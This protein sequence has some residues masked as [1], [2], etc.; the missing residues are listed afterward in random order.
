MRNAWLAV[1]VLLIASHAT[2]KDIDV[3]HGWVLY[4]D[5]ST[6]TLPLQRSP[7][8]LSGWKDVVCSDNDISA[9]VGQIKVFREPA[10]NADNFIAKLAAECAKIS[11]DTNADT[12]NEAYPA[13]RFEVAHGAEFQEVFHGEFRRDDPETQVFLPLPYVPIGFQVRTNFGKDYV[14]TLALYGVA[15][16]N[17]DTLGPYSNPK[18]TPE[19]PAYMARTGP[20]LDLVCP[21]QKVLVGVGVK[22]EPNKSK[23]RL[24]RIHCRTL[25]KGG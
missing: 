11:Y 15:H 18:R 23:I 25:R 19:L 6:V 20:T 12:M 2:A 13:A 16:Q 7:G 24:M 1:L 17:N 14:K 4:G 8:D 3:Q 10:G 5:I 22:Y 9:V 21:D